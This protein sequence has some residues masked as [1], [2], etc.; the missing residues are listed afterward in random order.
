MLNSMRLRNLRSFPNEQDVDY[1]NLKPITVLVGKNSS[2]KS[3]SLIH[4]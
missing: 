4:I 2:G 3:L 1:I